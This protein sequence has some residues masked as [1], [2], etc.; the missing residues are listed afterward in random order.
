[1]RKSQRNQP[2]SRRLNQ[3]VRAVQQHTK[4]RDAKSTIGRPMRGKR[5]S[6]QNEAFNA[7]EVWHEPTGQETTRYIVEPPRA[8]FFHPVSAR[9]VAHRLESLP[10]KF[11][12]GLEVVQ[13]SSM[14]RK[15]GLFPCYGM[16]WGAAIYL[17]PIDESLEEFYVRPPTPQQR[18]ETEMHGG[19]WTSEGDLWKL[20]WTEKTIRDFYLNNILIHELGHHNDHR[21]TN[22]NARERYA[23]WFAIEYGYRAARKLR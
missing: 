11:T 21:N 10:S 7:P 15:R 18:I 4:H 5:C 1:M 19:R 6:R 9:E 2:N 3:R 22:F 17:Y 20:S 8:G 13:F 23:N 12:Q 14:T 16:Q